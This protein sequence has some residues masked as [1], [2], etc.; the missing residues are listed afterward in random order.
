MAKQATD[1][2][3]LLT[4][5]YRDKPKIISF[6]TTLLT[7]FLDIQKLNDSIKYMLNLNN[8]EGAQL[9]MIGE[10]LNLP[11]QVSFQPTNGSSSVLDDY[12]YRLILKAKVA[13][14]QWKGTKS[15]LY[16]Y[17]KVLFPHNPLLMVDNQNMTISAVVVGLNSDMERDLIMHDY[18]IPRPAGVGMIYVFTDKPIY[19]QDLDT[20][21][22]K[23]FDEGYWFSF[24]GEPE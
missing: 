18:I 2:L 5:Q 14:N 22:L 9:D 1:Y 11:R 6:L 8:A 19:A 12:H 7:P 4:S 16:D 20:E 15:E 24:T 17:W 10:I 21:W 13:I 3:N 23:G